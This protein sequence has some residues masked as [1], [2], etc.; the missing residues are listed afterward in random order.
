MRSCLKFGGASGGPSPRTSPWHAARPCGRTTRVRVLKRPSMRASTSSSL[1]KPH[2]LRFPSA[3]DDGLYLL[4]PPS[5]SSACPSKPSHQSAS[6][7]MTSRD[8]AG[9]VT[10]A[11]ALAACCLGL[12]LALPG[13]QAHGYLSQPASRNLG[14]PW[15]NA[16]MGRDVCG[17]PYQGVRGGRGALAGAWRLLQ[18]GLRAL[19]HCTATG[20]MACRAPWSRPA[21]AD[22]RCWR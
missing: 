4:H 12:L 3:A 16:G 9:A 5:R 22:A 13:A 7:T 10:L 15:Q 19:A 20:W 18:A 21:C 1:V 6:A 8:R 17:G 14:H 2:T 11:A